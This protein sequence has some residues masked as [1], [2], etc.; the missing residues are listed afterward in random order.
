MKK[1][2]LYGLIYLATIFSIFYIANKK[3]VYEGQIAGYYI[4]VCKAG[5]NITC[6]Q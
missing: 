1:Y 5:L 4:L 2:T 3:I 6:E